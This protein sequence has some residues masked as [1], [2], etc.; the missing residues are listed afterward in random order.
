MKGSCPAGRRHVVP[1]STAS[2]TRA[3]NFALTSAFR[4]WRCLILVFEP[5]SEAATQRWAPRRASPSFYASWRC[6][7]DAQ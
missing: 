6:V 3:R 2:A 5:A 7:I 4:P 1:N